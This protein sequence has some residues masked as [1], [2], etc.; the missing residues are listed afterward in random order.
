ME[1][2][3]ISSFVDHKKRVH[4]RGIHSSYLFRGRS[5]F[6]HLLLLFIS[7]SSPLHSHSAHDTAPVHF[8]VSDELFCHL[9]LAFLLYTFSVTHRVPFLLAL[10][11][12]QMIIYKVLYSVHR[13]NIRKLAC[14]LNSPTALQQPAE[15]VT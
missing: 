4:S 2:A 12:I 7:G 15:S 14:Y 5:S 6:L 3:R 8:T 13:N 10:V 9:V 11:I 1:A